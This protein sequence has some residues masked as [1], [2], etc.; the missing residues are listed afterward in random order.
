MIFMLIPVCPACQEHW[1]KWA[2]MARGWSLPALAWE[3]LYAQAL[4]YG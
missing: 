1:G 3:H 4:Y 2:S